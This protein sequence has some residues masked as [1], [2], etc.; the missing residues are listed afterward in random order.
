M[1]HI[2]GGKHKIYNVWTKLDNLFMSR[3]FLGLSRQKFFQYAW[4]QHQSKKVAK[5]TI[6]GTQTTGESTVIMA[7]HND[8]KLKS[9]PALKTISWGLSGGPWYTGACTDCLEV[10]AAWDII[11]LIATPHRTTY[12]KLGFAYGVSGFTEIVVGI[13]ECE[14][15]T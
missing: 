6:I 8:I 3:Y 12:T 15:G 11:L 10:S 2:E 4:V 7:V 5:N 13:C 14:Q 9:T 1:T